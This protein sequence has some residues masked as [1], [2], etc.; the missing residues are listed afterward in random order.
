MIEF[1]TYRVGD[2]ST[3]DHSVLY[4]AEEE[5]KEW[6]SMNN[7]IQRLGMYLKKQGIRSM[8]EDRDI[9]L[10]KSYKEEAIKGI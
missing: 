9:K 3:S 8:D 7:P 1:I 5:L 2:H 4:R 6:K 10:R